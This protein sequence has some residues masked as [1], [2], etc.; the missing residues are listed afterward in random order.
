MINIWI[1]GL[2]VACSIGMNVEESL[3]ALVA[4]RRGIGHIKI[5]ETIHK[6][7]FKV[8]EIALTDHQLMEMLDIP[9]S[10]T[11]FIQGPA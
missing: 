7:K 11:G 2:G 4:G 9:Q 5:L 3:E 6:D 1:T 10:V 8:G